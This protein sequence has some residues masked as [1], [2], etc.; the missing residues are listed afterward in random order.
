MLVWNDNL[1]CNNIGFID[2]NDV[3]N[4]K[5]FILVGSQIYSDFSSWMGQSISKYFS[6]IRLKLTTMEGVLK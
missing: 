4:V 3:G 2:Q 6:I 5:M 1:D